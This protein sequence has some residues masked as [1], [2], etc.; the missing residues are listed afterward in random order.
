MLAQSRRD[1]Y[2]PAKGRTAW[3]QFYQPLHCQKRTP[4]INRHQFE[5]EED[6]APETISDKEDWLHWNG[7]L[8]N[9]NDS[10]DDCAADIESD[11]EQDNSIEDPERPQQ[12]DVS[13]PPYVSRLIRHTRKSKKQTEKVLIE[14]N[15]IETRRDM[16]VKP[17]QNRMCQCF[18]SFF[19]YLNQEFQLEI[20]NG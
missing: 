17:K 12:W 13:A 9:P 1:L 5:S 3:R 15:A 7:D 20:F 2:T 4:N 8:D 14:V 10:K 6:S 19:M 16:G 11:I 18:T